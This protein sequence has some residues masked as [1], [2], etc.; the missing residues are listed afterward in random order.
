MMTTATWLMLPQ[1][2]PAVADAAL[3][4]TSST[5]ALI[6]HCYAPR[7]NLHQTAI[8]DKSCYCYRCSMPPYTMLAMHMLPTTTCLI[9]LR[10]QHLLHLQH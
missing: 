8:T 1:H 5:H 10:C 7:E 3:H 6:A 9:Q 2:Q 4:A